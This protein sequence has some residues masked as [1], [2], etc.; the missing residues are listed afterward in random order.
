MRK[1]LTFML[2]LASVLAAACGDPKIPGVYR[3]D[4]QQGNVVT[5]EQLSQLERGMSKRKVQFVLGTPM[6]MDTFHQNRWDY[7]YSY[8]EGG[9]EREQRRVSL[10]FEDDALARIEGDVETALGE[11][12]ASSGPGE[13]VVTVPER[14]RSRGLLDFFTSPFG[15]DEATSAPQSPAPDSAPAEPPTTPASTPAAPPG[16]EG[17]APASAVPQPT[18]PAAAVPAADTTSAVAPPPSEQTPPAA[19]AAQPPDSTA[20]APAAPAGDADEEGFFSRLARSLGLG[21]DDGE[22]EDGEPAAGATGSP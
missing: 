2:A 8:Q 17:G 1:L 10:F 15:G 22:E 14:R 18:T 11:H 16:E 19:D 9:G 13:T 4:I 12:A 7:L 20:P 3:I 5:Q 21:G 6:I